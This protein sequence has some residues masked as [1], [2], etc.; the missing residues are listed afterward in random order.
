MICH[1]ST[2][3]LEFVKFVVSKNTF[4]LNK[5]FHIFRHVCPSIHFHLDFL[6]VEFLKTISFFKKARFILKVKI[7]SKQITYFEIGIRVAFMAV[8]TP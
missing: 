1:F 3:F 7:R 8:A 6:C 4:Q 5:I 2:K